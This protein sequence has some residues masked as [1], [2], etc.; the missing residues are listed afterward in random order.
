MSFADNLAS[1]ASLFG[2]GG[3]VDSLIKGT[4]IRAAQVFINLA[5]IFSQTG[6]DL[7]REQSGDD[8]V[9]VGG[10][11]RAVARQKGGSRAFLARRTPATR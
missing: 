8:P 1:A 6:G 10:P 9:F 2:V 11:G 3:R 4:S 5:G 7:S